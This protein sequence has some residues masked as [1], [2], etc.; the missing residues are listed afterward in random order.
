MSS[1]IT[2]LICG[3][4]GFVGRNMVEYFSE[5]RG[6]D[7]HA[8]CNV[9][10]NYNLSNVTWHRADLTQK[11]DVDKLI[12]EVRPDRIIQAAATTSGSKD[13]VSRPHIHVTDKDRK[14]VV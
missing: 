13:I 1:G 10:P 5:K 2:V 11:S 4:T 9:R 3:G 6:V 12:M 7:V 8:V 14:S